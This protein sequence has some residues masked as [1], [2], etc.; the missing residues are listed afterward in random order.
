MVGSYALACFESRSNDADLRFT[1]RV[2]SG[3]GVTNFQLYRI[4][5]NQHVLACLMPETIELA[6]KN[7]MASGKQHRSD[8][9]DS[10]NN[11]LCTRYTCLEL[12]RGSS[13]YHAEFVPRTGRPT[14]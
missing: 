14:K 8:A 5:I 12:L 6:I 1:T 4:V 10:V 3:N 11:L 7:H 9:C 13:Y 2:K